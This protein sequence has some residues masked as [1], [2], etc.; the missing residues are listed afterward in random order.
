MIFPIIYHYL[1]V[2]TFY[3]VMRGELDDASVLQV[4]YFIDWNSLAYQQTLQRHS[5]FVYDIDCFVHCY[6]MYLYV[7]GNFMML[8][9]KDELFLPLP[10]AAEILDLPVSFKNKL[11]YFAFSNYAKIRRCNNILQC[12]EGWTR[13][14]KCVTGL[15]F[16]RLKQSSL[17]ADIA[18]YRQ[19]CLWHL[20]LWALL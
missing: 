19:I 16:L 20:C 2:I 11:S 4:Y 13:W 17:S 14:C 12:Y 9:N 5:K 7:I 3:N 10:L 15:L 6:K 18:K 8:L 1:D